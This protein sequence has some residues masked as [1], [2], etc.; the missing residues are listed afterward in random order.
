[1][2]KKIL[3]GLLIIVLISGSLYLVIGNLKVQKVVCFSQFGPCNANL[4]LS[5]YNLQKKND[6][7]LETRLELNNLLKNDRS[8]LN[9][10]VRFKLPI[11]YEVN[12]IERKPVIGFLDSK[13][14][15]IILVDMDGVILGKVSSTVLPVV[16]TG[17]NLDNTQIVY[18]ANLVSTLYTFY[19]I[20]NARVSADGIVVDG[21]NGKEVDFPLAGDKDVLLGSLL[22]ILSRLPRIQEA[23]TINTIDLRFK[24]PVLR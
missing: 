12:V 1:M 18:I 11:S 5:I 2:I 14:N 13:T 22:L 20:K 24:N 9:Y 4:Q 19:N 3:I 23:S 17:L 7:I 21:I 10:S 6:S 8:V 16:T 15:N